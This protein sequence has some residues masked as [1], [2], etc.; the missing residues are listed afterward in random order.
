MRLTD[1]QLAAAHSEAPR[2]VVISGPGTGKTATL[3]ERVR[4]LVQERDV[5]PNEIAL[6]TFTRR[7]AGEMQVRLGCLGIQSTAMLCGTFHAV[8]F[9]ILKQEGTAIG[10]DPDTLTIMEPQECLDVVKRAGREM[11]FYDGSRWKKGIKPKDV[12][13]YRESTSAPGVCPTTDAATTVLYRRYK[14]LLKHNNTIDYPRILSYVAILFDDRPDIAETWQKR[15]RFIL[16][17]EV[18]DCN[19]EQLG[20]LGNLRSTS[21][22]TIGDFDQS[23]YGWRGSA[24]E[25]VRKQWPDAET[26]TLTRSHRCAGAI[27][28]LLGTV[29]SRDVKSAADIEGEVTIREGF[30]F[31]IANAVRQA[32]M[33]HEE[34]DIA[35]L[36]RTRR[37]LA[38]MRL[39]LDDIGVKSHTPGDRF[40]IEE[41][42]DFRGVLA[43]L[44][45][46]ANPNDDCSAMRLMEFNGTA[47]RRIAQLERAAVDSGWN[48]FRQLVFEEQM[49]I[50]NPTTVAQALTHQLCDRSRIGSDVLQWWLGSFGDF[51]LATAIEWFA[52]RD[53]HD[54]LAD[55]AV[56]LSTVHSAKGLEWPVVFVVDL[57]EGLFPS[58]MD[59]RDDDSLTECKRVFY[60]ACSRAC[61]TLH[62]FYRPDKKPSRFLDGMEQVCGV[63]NEA[64]L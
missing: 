22:F 55:N 52:H 31:H 50:S 5:E 62:L 45:V 30:P 43:L 26:Y 48:L 40:K 36:A 44:K 59:K 61:R 6:L 24:P 29:F 49:S 1:E 15:T 9:H 18:Q 16:V 38:D 51:P 37:S 11:G 54:D 46:L 28:R 53:A 34:K 60:V 21:L 42:P 57:N 7:A 63:N 35:I 10:Y 33:D 56:T 20:F 32:M 25:H 27:T 17:D 13:E 58:G 12:L 19:L 47:P 14:Q 8:G 39:A 4:W 64:S 23:I 2:T 41:Q 3:I